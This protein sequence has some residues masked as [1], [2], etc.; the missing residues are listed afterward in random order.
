MV[1]LFPGIFA[2]NGLLVVPAY[3]LIGLMEWVSADPGINRTLVS[4]LKAA[5]LTGD[6]AS[7]SIRRTSR[8]LR[9]P[10]ATSVIQWSRRATVFAR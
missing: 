2:S 8:T 10:L 6:D 9:H 7:R 4:G 3:L 5:S 1:P